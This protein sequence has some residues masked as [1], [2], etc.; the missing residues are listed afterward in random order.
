LTNTENSTSLSISQERQCMYRHKAEALSCNS[1][2][3]GKAISVT[4]SVCVY[5]FLPHLSSIQSLYT[6]LYCQLWPVWLYHIFPHYL[7]NGTIF[8]KVM[9]HKT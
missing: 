4:Y 9:E 6:L 3:N 2:R 8:G 5:V 1:Y 7:I